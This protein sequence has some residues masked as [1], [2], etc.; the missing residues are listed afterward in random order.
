MMPN[1]KRKR[2]ALWRVF[3]SLHSDDCG[4]SAAEESDE[5]CDDK[6]Y[7]V[8]WFDSQIPLVVKKKRIVYYDKKYTN[9]LDDDMGTPKSKAQ[10]RAERKSHFC[11]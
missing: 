1:T 11:L 10:M 4:C 2:G 6:V 5:R 3:P 9:G 7:K 8:S